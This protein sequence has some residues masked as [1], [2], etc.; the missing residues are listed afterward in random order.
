MAL[1]VDTVGMVAFVEP[2]GLNGPVGNDV[3]IVVKWAGTAA[4]LRT[5]AVRGQAHESDNLMA[6]NPHSIIALSHCTTAGGYQVQAHYPQRDR[7]PPERLGSSL[8]LSTRLNLGQILLV[9]HVA[10]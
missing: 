8:M 1:G 4:R 7:C 5:L 9:S 6:Y 10:Q 2:R 3:E